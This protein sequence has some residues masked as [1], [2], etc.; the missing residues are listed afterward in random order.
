MLKRLV[1]FNVDSQDL[2]RFMGNVDTTLNPIIQNPILDYNIVKSVS[3]SIGDNLV[4]HKLNRVPQG[5][6]L[7]R[8]RSPANIYDKQD[9]NQTPK[10]N[11][12]LHSDA[13]V[14]VDIY[15]F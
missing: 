2:N 11:F 1:T 13:V 6:Y 4:N 12:I 3:L 14:T 5:F 8:Q 15:F 9:S 7:V 10:V